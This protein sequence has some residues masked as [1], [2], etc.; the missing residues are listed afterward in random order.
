MAPDPLHAARLAMLEGSM[1]A[2]LREAAQDFGPN[3]APT[4]L[5]AELSESGIDLSYCRN[6]FPVSGEGL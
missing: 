5:T 2:L 3:D 4:S 1:L 6:G